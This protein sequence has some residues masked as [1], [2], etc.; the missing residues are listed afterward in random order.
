MQRTATLGKY[1]S[2]GRRPLPQTPDEKARNKPPM[3][4]VPPTISGTIPE[5]AL[6]P[7][8]FRSVM[9]SYLMKRKL[10]QI[11]SV[12]DKDEDKLCVIQ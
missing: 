8:N 3:P 9:S 10:L 11:S 12:L 5:P 4:K 2:L 1:S 6:N 7:A